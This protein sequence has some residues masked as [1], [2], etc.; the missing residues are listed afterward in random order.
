[1]EIIEQSSIAKTPR[2][3][4][5][6]GIVVTN[7]FIAVIDGS[8]SKS[9]YRHSLFNSNGRYAMLLISRYIRK[10]PKESTCSQFMKGVTAYIRKHYKKS[11]LPRLTERPEDRLTASVVVFSRLQRELWMIGDCQC[12]IDGELFENPKPE[13]AVYA[14]KRAEKAKE[15]LAAGTTVDE[16]LAHDAARDFILADIVDS[17]KRQNITFSVIDGFPIPQKLVP[18]ITLDFQPH[19]IVLA[20]DGYPFLCPT[21]TESERRLEEQRR[22]DPLNI[23]S[24]IASKAFMTGQD[25]FDDRTYIRFDV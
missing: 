2:K 3:K 24:F 6:D 16:L 11:M 13:E 10:M 19:E 21:L 7:D 18:V 23:H 17:T 14:A 5:E 1:M 15:L 22:N 20:S 4:S 12:L 25:S 8:T 9:Q